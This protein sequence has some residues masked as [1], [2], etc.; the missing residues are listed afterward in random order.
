[1]LSLADGSYEEWMAQVGAAFSVGGG[2][3]LRLAGVQAFAAAG[4]RPMGLA[5]SRA[6]VAL[7][8]PVGG[9]TMAPDL[10]YTV[11]HREYGPLQI[12][13]SASTNTRTPA[14]M[15]AVFN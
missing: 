9:A 11:N 7:F 14:R 12:F 13:L 15:I 8:D 5:R 2:T 4:A 3:V 1:M 6:F 10:I